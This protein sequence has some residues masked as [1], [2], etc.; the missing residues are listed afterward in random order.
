MVVCE[1]SGLTPRD[2]GCVRCEVAMDVVY[3]LEHRER[4]LEAPAERRDAR[5]GSMMDA[6]D[7]WLAR[8]RELEPGAVLLAERIAGMVAA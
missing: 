8:H 2:C 6:S 5:W 3:G 7:R 4:L 1:T